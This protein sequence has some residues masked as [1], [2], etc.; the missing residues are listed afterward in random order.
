MKYTKFKYLYPPRPK[1]AVSRDELNY[2]NNDI[3]LLC[4]SKLNGSNSLIFISPSN[5]VIVMN[6][7]GSRLTNFRINEK[8]IILL[9]RGDGWI[10]LNAEYMNK[11]KY[12]ENNKIF[13]HKLVIFDILVY[14][15]DYLV[16]TTFEKRIELLDS[17]YGKKEC[18]K[19]YL[20]EVSDNIYRVKTYIDNFENLYN[21]LINIDMYEGLV[22]K[23][24]NG[25]LEMGLTEN[26]TSRCQFKIRK[27][28]KNYKY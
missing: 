28:T 10:V 12:D 26:N 23:K 2:F 25:K 18:D 22:L 20:Y 13:N 4:Q 9:Y 5:Q 15:S 27:P 3:S 16:G 17:L 7:H 14:N 11:S 1:N 6:R 19:K 21:E 8:E 24:K